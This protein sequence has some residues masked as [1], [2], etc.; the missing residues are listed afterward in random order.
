M[1]AAGTPVL[2]TGGSG[3]VLAGI[4]TTLVAQMDDPLEAA[5][6]AAWIHGRAAEIAGA[7]G[8]RGHTVDDVVDA[9][10]LVWSEKPPRPRPPVLA[11]LPKIDA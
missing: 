4:V 10:T 2:A 1:S 11:E 5:A 6:A 7:D 3:D 8:I 9:L